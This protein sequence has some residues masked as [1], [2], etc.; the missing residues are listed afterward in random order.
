MAKKGKV[1]FELVNRGN[2]YVLV[3]SK[4]EP[5]KYPRTYILPREV[6]AKDGSRTRRIRWF[7]TASSPWAD[8]QDKNGDLNIFAKGENGLP[9]IPHTESRISFDKGF[10]LVDERDTVKLHYLRLLPNNIAN[11]GKAFKERNLIKEARDAAKGKLGVAQGTTAVMNLTQE[12]LLHAFTAYYPDEGS[13][14]P[15]IMR[16]MLIDA[17]EYYAN[18]GQL[19]TFM[20][21]LDSTETYETYR[22]VQLFKLGILEFTGDGR[23]AK[24][25]GAGPLVDIPIG[26]EPYDF[27]TEWFLTNENG[28]VARRNAIKKYKDIMQVREAAQIA[29][30]TSATEAERFKHLS[31]KDLQEK[32]KQL[33]ILHKHGAKA[34][35]FGQG[36]IMVQFNISTSKDLVLALNDRSSDVRRA[37][38]EMIERFDD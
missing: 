14:D 32:M 13:H 25:V 15:S 36:D 18:A 16:A 20:H 17:A 30:D 24:W 2:S 8:E 4:G 27:I 7:N 26:E 28:R 37:A 31:G 33:K 6:N 22:T 12:K 21:S 38:I 35:K 11:G 29:E 3:D 23:I 19:D 1:L 10:L 9:H 34:Y 5:V